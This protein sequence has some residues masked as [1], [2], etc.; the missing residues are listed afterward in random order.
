M[1]AGLQAAGTFAMGYQHNWWQILTS[2]FMRN[3]LIGGTLVALAAGLIGY[4]VIVR[5][6][7]FAAHA[8]AHIGL[9]GATGAALLGL[10]VGLGLLAFCVGG[11]LVIGALGSRAHDR[12]VATGTVLA[13]ATGFGLFFN[14]LA[15][16][17][18]STLTNVLFGNLLAITH[19]QLLNFTALLLLL[20]ATV[21]FVFRP[22][23][24]ASVNPQVAEA[25]GVPVRVLSVLFMVLLGIAVTMAVLAVGTLLLFALVVTPAATAIMV[26]AR[27]IL[28]MA[29]STGIS[30]VSVWAGLAVSAIFNMPPSFVIV[31]IACGFWLAVWTV[32]RVR[33]SAIH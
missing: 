11:A 28:A 26:T 19:Q 18:S 32:D 4:F 17:N 8:L 21:V 13:L 25:K 10:P 22:L 9:P 15:T 20:A 33:N 5:N 23:L 2:A 6:T 27:P 30:V 31:T 24:F 7:A 1:S 3:A 12:E 29:I 16:K 14:S